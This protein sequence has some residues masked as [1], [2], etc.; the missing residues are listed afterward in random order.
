MFDLVI[1]DTEDDD[2]EVGDR[3][4]PVKGRVGSVGVANKEDSMIH[5][6]E[7]DKEDDDDKEDEDTNIQ[8]M[9]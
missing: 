9:A 1:H 7:D 2:K 6:T 5:D 3:M 8:K 4:G